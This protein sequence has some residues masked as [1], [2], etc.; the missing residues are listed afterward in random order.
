ML[1]A[2]ADFVSAIPDNP[3]GQA[4]I[5][6]L[7]GLGVGT[8]YVLQTDVGRMG[9]YF[10]KTMLMVCSKTPII[11]KETNYIGDGMMVKGKKAMQDE[12]RKM[13]T[14]E[15]KKSSPDKKQLARLKE[16]MNRVTTR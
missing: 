2:E 10:L 7:K 1:G 12:F 13:Y 8:N 5:N 3:I 16:K 9:L 14:V 11:K 4:C 6:V 15:E